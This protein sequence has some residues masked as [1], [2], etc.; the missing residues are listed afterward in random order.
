MRLAKG[1]A[2]DGIIVRTLCPSSLTIL[3]DGQIAATQRASINRQKSIG[4]GDGFHL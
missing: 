2:G 3:R 4:L 1:I